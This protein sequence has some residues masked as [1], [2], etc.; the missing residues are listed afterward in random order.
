MRTLLLSL[1]FLSGA[2]PAS[3]TPVDPV[4]WVS[5]DVPRSAEEASLAR[6]EAGGIVA[7][8]WSNAVVEV[9]AFS[10]VEPLPLA[11]LAERLTDQDPR[12]DPWL[13]SLPEVFHPKTEVSRLWVAPSDLRAAETLV[14]TVS[15]GRGEVSPPVVTAWGLVGF[16]LFFLILRLVWMGLSWTVPK[17][18]RFWGPTGLSAVFLVVGLVWALTAGGLPAGGKPQAGPSWARHLWFQE[19]WAEGASW[20]DWK[21]GKAWTYPSYERRDGRL[22]ETSVSLAVPDGAWARAG[23]DAL[24]PHHAARI[25]GPENP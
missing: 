7:I 22:S 21:P 15:R 2:L 17:D 20:E 19:A 25:S 4:P 14:G 16:S 10:G 12:W 18:L 8:G 6:L 11:S 13:R 5:F 1:S 3:S 9:S 24:D 23:F